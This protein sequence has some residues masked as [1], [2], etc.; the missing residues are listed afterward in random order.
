M[1]ST[2]QKY[3]LHR[4]QGSSAQ[5]EVKNNFFY[6]AWAGS[7]TDQEVPTLKPHLIYLIDE[8]TTLICT[9][10][11]KVKINEKNS[12]VYLPAPRSSLTAKQHIT[13]WAT[14]KYGH[15]FN[16]VTYS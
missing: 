14:S 15:I 16:F 7:Q 10:A 1:G 6:P 2:I 9:L 13:Q 4:K 12:Y 8:I 3:L 11:P 5:A